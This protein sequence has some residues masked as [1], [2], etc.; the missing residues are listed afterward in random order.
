MGAALISAR[1]GSR[2]GSVPPNA[3]SVLFS[4]WA[5]HGVAHSQREAGDADGDERREGTDLAVRFCVVWATERL[6]TMV[7]LDGRVC[8]DG[9]LGERKVSH[10]TTRSTSSC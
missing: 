10:I 7:P 6:Q 2:T 3:T 4:I 5:L 8:T 9:A 1:S